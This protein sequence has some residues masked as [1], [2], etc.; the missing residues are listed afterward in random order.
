MQSDSDKF[1]EQLQHIVGR[2]SAAVR[3]REIRESASKVQRKVIEEKLKFPSRT[4]AGEIRA[5]V[6][7]RQAERNFRA[8][9]QSCDVFRACSSALA[10]SM[11]T[12]D[13]A[14]V[15]IRRAL[16]SHQ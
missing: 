8:L 9:A 13:L 5:A 4:E 12:W 14:S 16:A 15:T 6:K 10:P 1:L 2:E 11:K 7:R 3:L